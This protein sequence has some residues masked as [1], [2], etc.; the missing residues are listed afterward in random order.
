MSKQ[1]IKKVLQEAMA[2]KDGTIGYYVPPIVPGIHEFEKN[3]LAP[4]VLDVT[5]FD[6]PHL[7]HDYMD[8]KMSTPKKKIG[9]M[10]KRADKGTKYAEANHDFIT[11]GESEWIDVDRIPLNEDLG[12]WFGT[13]KKPKG[14]SQPKG[15]WV[16]ICRKKEGGGH[17]PCG[18]PDTDKGAYPKC[19]AAGVA[20]KM[21]DSQK[22]AACQQKRKAEKKDTQTGKGQKPVMT[23]YKP[24][25][26]SIMRKTIKITESD[27]NRII[28]RILNEEPKRFE[29]MLTRD[30]S[31]REPT[32]AD[33][34]YFV[35][36]GDT[37]DVH[38]KLSGSNMIEKLNVQL[39]KESELTVK[40]NGSA[41][42]S[43]GQTKVANQ[44][45]S[46]ILTQ[47]EK[48][49][50]NWVVYT[51]EEDGKPAIGRFV[52]GNLLELN[53]LKQDKVEKKLKINDIYSS[54]DYIVSVKPKLF[55]KYSGRGYSFEVADSK[56]AA[57]STV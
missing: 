39:P 22:R 23:S 3:Q 42:L 9:K 4:F 6:S 7:A 11:L 43:H 10:E 25:N 24:K 57:T 2:A 53:L 52:Q 40:F 56:D 12:V 45:A 15:P 17:P 30:Y 32:D 38:A 49:K 5:P 1:I 16:N 27:L 13:K 20:A 19:R 47:M 51:K 26:E 55:D 36:N 35:K 48:S 18:R 29:Y 28:K 31:Y 41:F 21:T 50:G 37:Y 46:L 8:G 54:K 33:E 14:S 34:I 44:I